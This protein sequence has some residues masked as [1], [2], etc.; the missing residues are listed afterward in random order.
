M[1]DDPGVVRLV[2]DAR[3]GDR[4]AWDRIIE[5]YA[6]LVWG[7]CMR[8]RLGRADADDVGQ[9]VWL[10][11][12]EHI[13]TIREP[14][15]LPG[16]L[17]RTT[18]NECL[19]LLEVSG[20]RVTAEL[21]T[22]AVDDETGYLEVEQELETARR[23]TALREAFADL[24]PHCQELLSLLFADPP[25]PYRDVGAQLCM[26]IGSIGPTRE[27]CLAELRRSPALTALAEAERQE[28]GG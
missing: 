21:T 17:A 12:F 3:A 18:R 23:H 14:A 4:S 2:V 24:R 25:T 15:A 10:K 27:R 9:T 16:W 26:K 8:F 20:H 11:L 7:V 13:M 6:P 1:Y 19:R 22:L 5:R 28:I